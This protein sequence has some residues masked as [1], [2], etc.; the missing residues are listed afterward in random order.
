MYQQ[1]I[2][3]CLWHSPLPQTQGAQFPLASGGLPPA[4]FCKTMRIYNL[5]LQ[6]SFVYSVFRTRV[7][8]AVLLC[9]PRCRRLSQGSCDCFVWEMCDPSAVLLQTASK[10]WRQ[11]ADICLI[12]NNSCGFRGSGLCIVF[13]TCTA[14]KFLYSGQ[15][16]NFTYLLPERNCMW[17]KS[18]KHQF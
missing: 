12:L 4:Y 10:Q 11:F 3:S 1:L 16:P 15:I 14:V 7:E 9:S 6:A 17:E 5:Q 13:S 8:T 18:G 2:F